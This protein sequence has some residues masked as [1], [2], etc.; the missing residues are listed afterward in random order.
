MVDKKK[1]ST[2]KKVKGDTKNSKLVDLSN[3]SPQTIL[4]KEDRCIKSILSRRIIN[5]NV[6]NEEKTRK[7][8]IELINKYTTDY[9]RDYDIFIGHGYVIES[10]VMSK[11]CSILSEAKSYKYYDKVTLTTLKSIIRTVVR[12]T[13]HLIYVFSNS[14]STLR[15]LASELHG[16]SIEF[17]YNTVVAKAYAEV[18]DEMRLRQKERGIYN[19]KNS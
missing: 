17:D 8:K 9:K 15:Y 4:V 7:K 1:A 14:Q 12:D 5:E 13:F 2:A 6:D 11:C 3:Q 19:G 16:G 10:I 18:F